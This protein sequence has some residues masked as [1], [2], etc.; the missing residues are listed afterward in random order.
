[1]YNQG[2]VPDKTPYIFTVVPFCLLGK[3]GHTFLREFGTGVPL[4]MLP[5]PLATWRN[6]RFFLLWGVVC[7]GVITFLVVAHMLDASQWT[8]SVHT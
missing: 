2:G 3:G 5:S 7:L 6:I 1:M 8:A 4:F